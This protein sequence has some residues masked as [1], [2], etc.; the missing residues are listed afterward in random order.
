M[1]RTTTDAADSPAGMSPPD[2][3]LDLVDR[4]DAFGHEL[5]AG[6]E[7]LGE[8][9]VHVLEDLAGRGVLHDDLADVVVHHEQLEHAAPTGEAGLEAARAAVGAED[10]AGALEVL[11]H[12]F[13]VLRRRLHPDLAERA[14]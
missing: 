6:L 14:E 10:L 11:A 9:G 1:K 5:V 12:L 13:H 8:L 4:R 7:Q 2:D 3:A